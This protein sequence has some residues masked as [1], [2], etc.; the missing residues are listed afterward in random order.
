VGIKGTNVEKW[1]VENCIRMV[2]NCYHGEYGPISAW[3]LPRTNDY[4]EDFS[5][6]DVQGQIYY[7]DT[8]MYI[9]FTGSNSWN[10]WA[11]N[12]K[13]WKVFLYGDVA[14]ETGFYVQYNQV[15]EFIVNKLSKY[16]QNN[17]NANIFFTGHSLGSAIASLCAFDFYNLS[18]NTYLILNGCPQTGNSAFKRAIEKRLKGNILNIVYGND[19]FVR[20][21]GLIFGF[22]AHGKI[23]NLV[24]LW[25]RILNP[26]FYLLGNP[27][28]HYPQLE[29]E[30]II[31]NKNITTKQL[32]LMI[33]EK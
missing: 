11:D 7:I 26:V 28:D 27:F 25:K 33:G 21:P 14:V 17:K 2:V 31:N 12:L 4:K 16:L 10:D 3:L 20:L 30:V 32:K 15:R 24:P 5:I 9:S 29:Y 22:R 8:G 18:K 13:F 23:W 6:G 19:L 1:M